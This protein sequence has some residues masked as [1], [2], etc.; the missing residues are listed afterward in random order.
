MF[1]T[2]LS[3]ILL[4]AVTGL[5]GGFTPCALGI[6]TIFVGALA[7]KPRVVRLGNWLLLAITRAALLTGLGLLFGLIGEVVNTTAALYQQAIN[8][9]LIILGALFIISRFRP[10]PLPALSLAN[11][12][13]F[14]ER[15]SL[16]AMGLLFGLDISACI[17]PLVLALLAQTVLL[18][19]WV[20]GALALFVFGVSLSLPALAVLSL[21]GADRWLLRM[22]QR[23][24][25]AFYITAGGFLVLFGTAE[26]LL[27]VLYT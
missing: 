1:E 21:E 5:A 14:Q 23:Y 24:R 16:V 4:P 26:F 3:I 13:A 6:N 27:T 2:V 22:S 9:G 12:D 15:R 7:G 19:N 17:A 18:G 20:E 10:L 11:P 25:N 8:V